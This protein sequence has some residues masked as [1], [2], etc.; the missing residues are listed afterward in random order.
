MRL[1]KQTE[2][3]KRQTML[4]YNTSITKGEFFSKF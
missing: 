3:L 2:M 1:K 4:G